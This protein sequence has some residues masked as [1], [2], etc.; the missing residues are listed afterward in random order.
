[1]PAAHCFTVAVRDGDP[2]FFDSPKK[3]GEKKG[4]PSAPSSA[5]PSIVVSQTIKLFVPDALGALE[6]GFKPQ[7]DE[8]GTASTPNLNIATFYWVYQYSA[9]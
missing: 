1:M 4:D 2:I 7:L 6:R 9:Y 8:R 5:V 3:M